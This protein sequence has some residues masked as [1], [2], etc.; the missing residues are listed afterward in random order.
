MKTFKQYIREKH[1]KIHDLVAE[2]EA[3]FYTLQGKEVKG[4]PRFVDIAS[5]QGFNRDE[6]RIGRYYFLD[7]DWLKAN[8]EFIGSAM[9]HDWAG[10][11]FMRIPGSMD[12]ELTA[13]YATVSEYENRKLAV[14]VAPINLLGRRLKDMFVHEYTHAVNTAKSDDRIPWE[15][16]HGAGGDEVKAWINDPE[17]VN[18]VLHDTISFLKTAPPSQIAIAVKGSEKRLSEAIFDLVVDHIAVFRG[19]GNTDDLPTSP[20]EPEPDYAYQW[21]DK[22]ADGKKWRSIRELLSDNKRLWNKYHRRLVAWIA[23]ELEPTIQD[24]LDRRASKRK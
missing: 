5:E 10:L 22:S 15:P 12:S 19:E 17:E 4:D 18:A 23:K 3:V 20:Y 8:T 1:D 2:A 16:T 24:I 14:V 6:T 21:F 7:V 11:L 13:A 9:G